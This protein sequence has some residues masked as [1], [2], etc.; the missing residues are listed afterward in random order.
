MEN[1]WRKGPEY[2]LNGPFTQSFFKD[3]ILG[4]ENCK[5]AFRESDFRVSLF[6]VGM[7]EG[8]L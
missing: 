7:S 4:S 1:Y 6:L 2:L 5:Q 3:P 8:H